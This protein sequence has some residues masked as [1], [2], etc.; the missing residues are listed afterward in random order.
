[1]MRELTKAGNLKLFDEYRKIVF[2]TIM[3]KKEWQEEAKANFKQK[4]N[5]WWTTMNGD[6]TD[7]QLEL[8]NAAIRNVQLPVLSR[9]HSTLPSIAMILDKWVVIYFF[10]I[11]T[12]QREQVR[13][14][15]SSPSAL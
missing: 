5:D 4:F 11:T 12:K 8:L 10:A 13:C 2:N 3:T 9:W 1:M 14:R 6:D 7:A 15:G